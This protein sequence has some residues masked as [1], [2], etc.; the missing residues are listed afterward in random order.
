MNCNG[1][2]R[3]LSWHNLRHYPGGTEEI[4][5]DVSKESRGRDLI[6][7]SSDHETVVLIPSLQRS[8]ASCSYKILQNSLIENV[9]ILIESRL[10]ATTTR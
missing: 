5:K 7:L 2:D 6:P 10:Y 3:K 4:T 1:S 8:V 9:Q